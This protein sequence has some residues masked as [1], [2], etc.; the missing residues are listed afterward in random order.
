MAGES[1]VVQVQLTEDGSRPV[2]LPEQF[3]TVEDM[4]TSFKEAQAT[5]T[6]LSQT[7]EETTPAAAPKA[8]AKK[9]DDGLTPEMRSALETFA[10][11][12]ET[13]RKV[14][15]EG[16]IGVEGLAAL[17]TYISGEAIAPALKASYEAA[18]ESGNEAMVDANFNMIRQAFEATNGAFEGPQNMVA[19]IAGGGI[20]VPQ[21]TNPF[22]SLAEQLTAQRDPKYQTDSAFRKDVENR[23]AISP[24]Y[25]A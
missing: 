4:A 1:E 25:Q 8:P 18:L 15:F 2:G 20:T 22:R 3:A 13:Q 12:N 24:T 21:G 9:T 6:K 11:F 17:D 7:T 14:R 5:I 19:G 16:Q 23:I 10:T